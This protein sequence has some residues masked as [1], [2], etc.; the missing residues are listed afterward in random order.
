[1]LDPRVPSS[2]LVYGSYT[3]RVDTTIK[4]DGLVRDRLAQLA[5]DRGT[6]IRDLVAELAVN[7]PTQQELAERA[8]AATGY[9][10]DRINP[11]LTDADLAAG[12][13]FWAALE[14]GAMPTVAET[15]QPADE[16]AA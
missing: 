7:T 12:E 10:R 4:V 9:V 8:A 1:M 6:T 14:S 5:R 16:K 13:R 11:Q 15:Y 3:R 2:P